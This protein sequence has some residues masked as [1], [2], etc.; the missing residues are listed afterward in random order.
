[1]RFYGFKVFMSTL[2][3]YNMQL[4]TGMY[5]TDYSQ[6]ISFLLSVLTEN[7]QLLVPSVLPVFLLCKSVWMYFDL[8]SC[9]LSAG[10]VAS[11]TLGC[12]LSLCHSCPIVTADPFT[13]LHIFRT[14]SILAI[15]VR[16]W[17]ILL[18]PQPFESVTAPWVTVLI[19]ISMSP[20]PFHSHHQQFSP[21]SQDT[22]K[23]F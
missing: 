22:P 7:E 14:S 5:S 2:M 10:F 18:R 17:R 12:S 8:T 9:W 3:S 20:L 23:A 4:K 1:M 15:S 21:E 6:I 19:F 13:L 11:A 16:W